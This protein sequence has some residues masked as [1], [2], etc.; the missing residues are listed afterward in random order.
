MTSW[1][2]CTP[3]SLMG[4][5]AL[6]RSGQ[7]SVAEVV[8]DA[9]YRIQADD[10][11]VN[12]CSV[13][14]IESARAQAAL[15]DRELSLGHTR[16]PLHGVP[17]VVKDNF[18]ICGTP[19]A[20]GSPLLS[21]VP[22]TRSAFAVDAIERAGGVIVAKTNMYELAY[23]G[24]NPEFGAV[25]NP[26]NADRATGGSSSGV[27][28]A[29]AAG[30]VH[31]GLGTDSGGSARIPAGYCGVVGLKPTS[32][33]IPTDGIVPVSPTLDHV[34][35]L[36]RSVEDVLAIMKGIV[37]SLGELCTARGLGVGFA[38]SD[39]E[40]LVDP[41]VREALVNARQMLREAGARITSVSLPDLDRAREVKWTIS[42]VEAA[43]VHRV[44]LDSRRESIQ[45]SV[46]NLLED[47]EPITADAYQQAL[48]ARG[49]LRAELASVFETVDAV[50]LPALPGGAP[51]RDATTIELGR[52]REPALLAMTRF[53]SL[54]NVSGTPA[55][56]VPCGADRDGMPLS[57]QI[58][59]AAGRDLTAL[60]VARHLE[61][62]LPVATRSL[63][64][65]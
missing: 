27:A 44:L 57:V 48:A 47:G 61:R 58:A 52:R 19:T 43:R 32:G 33:L 34:G 64:D 40:Q 10:E 13:L 24:P 12:A 22:A 41:A 23:G 50:V 35:P 26:R 56:V 62:T 36:G 46:R 29:V 31:G 53:M 17:I 20:A 3:P 16:G 21:K 15:L 42:A 39:V 54:F 28:A 37:P 14:L 59:A 25:L 45:P 5:A 65:A 4:V 1:R 11:V 55:V 60:S 9:F 2:A 6:V 18:D 7:A 38:D 49:Q 8:D 51:M 30:F 63:S